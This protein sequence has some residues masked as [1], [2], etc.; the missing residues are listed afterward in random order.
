[1]KTKNLINVSRKLQQNSTCVN[2]KFKLQTICN[3]YV[4]QKQLKQTV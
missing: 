2:E 3:Y 1:M 4:K